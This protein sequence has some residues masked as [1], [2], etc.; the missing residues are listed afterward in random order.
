MRVSR[1]FLLILL[2]LMLSTVFA[3]CDN[4]TAEVSDTI[5]ETP[6]EEVTEVEITVP[7]E[8]TEG[9]VTDAETTETETETETETTEIA[10]K[11]WLRTATWLPI[12]GYILRL[13]AAS[14]LI[15]FC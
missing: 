12:S 8:T 6:S 14:V 2:T 4:G 15:S 3:S 1:I 10:R 7:V 11:K 5:P 13:K 9:I